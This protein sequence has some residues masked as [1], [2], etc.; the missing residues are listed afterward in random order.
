MIHLA[1]VITRR[2]WLG[3][4]AVHLI[5]EPGAGYKTGFAISLA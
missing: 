4:K 1:E 5:D 3:G 2:F